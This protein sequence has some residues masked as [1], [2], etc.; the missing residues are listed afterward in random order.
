M[1]GRKITL[2]PLRRSRFEQTIAHLFSQRAASRPGQ[3]SRAASLGLAGLVFLGFGSR[4]TPGGRDDHALRLD[5]VPIVVHDL[6]SAT[7][8]YR[9]LLGFSIKPGRR[10]PNGLHN[11]HVK[12]RDGSALEL[13]TVQEPTDKLSREYA[14]LLE[15]GEGA[16]FVSLHGGPIAGLAE[17]ARTLALPATTV[18]GSNFD[19]LVFPLAHPL[20]YLFF[21]DLR[22]PPVDEEQHLTHTNTALRL[23]SVWVIAPAVNAADG[24]LGRL[25]ARRC[26][27]GAASASRAE[28]EP[29]AAADTS[30]D[31]EFVREIG[32]DSGSLLAVPIEAAFDP[33][34]P[35]V[36]V[37]VEVADLEAARRFAAALLRRQ[38]HVEEDWRGRFV[39][40]PPSRTHG[41]WI[42]FLEPGTMGKCSP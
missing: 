41:V 2:G 7:A 29:G 12:F 15:T 22:S 32:L 14:R 4:G 27:T 11:A 36:G 33:G 13:I 42:E 5:H 16:V 39:R 20:H 23:A 40:I 18:G 17:A 25:G 8:T 3:W 6:E 19:W 28:S 9:D 38:P 34:W 37:T 24:L 31:V 26:A 30:E 21:I 1:Y 35:I 10:H